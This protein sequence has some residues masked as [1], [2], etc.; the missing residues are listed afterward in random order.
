MNGHHTGD[1]I[2]NFR[3][4]L[5]HELHKHGVIASPDTTN[6]RP[7]ISYAFQDPRGGDIEEIASYHDIVQ[8]ERK[9]QART[10]KFPTK[11]FNGCNNDKEARLNLRHTLVRT[12]MKSSMPKDVQDL[13]H[14]NDVYCWSEKDVN[15]DKEIH[16]NLMWASPLTDNENEA[17]HCDVSDVTINTQVDGTQLTDVSRKVANRNKVA[18]RKVPAD[19]KYLENL[20]C[21]PMFDSNVRENELHKLTSVSDCDGKY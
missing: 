19:I 6:K 18:D 3:I 15:K 5:L 9:I 17:S 1:D 8:F 13:T 14:L 7:A 2:T 16:D 12:N 11:L 21:T 10:E 4:A 20:Y